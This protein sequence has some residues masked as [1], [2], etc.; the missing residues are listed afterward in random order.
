MRSLAIKKSPPIGV[1]ERVD[2][3][4]S[5]VEYPLSLSVYTAF[6]AT[7]FATSSSETRVLNSR[8]DM[9]EKRTTMIFAKRVDRLCFD[10]NRASRGVSR[11]RTR[12][13]APQCS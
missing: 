12:V 7:D 5:G 10:P 6:C 1:A 4:N 2:Q 8:S 9:V 11:R 3:C 13:F